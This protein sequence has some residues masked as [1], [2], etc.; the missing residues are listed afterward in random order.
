[1]LPWAALSIYSWQMPHNRLLFRSKSGAKIE[2]KIETAKC[3][4]NNFNY[5]CSLSLPARIPR[6]F[7]SSFG[8]GRGIFYGD[9]IGCSPVARELYIF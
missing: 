6:H 7:A 5:L 8:K 9:Y 2:I 1:M 4:A 3:K